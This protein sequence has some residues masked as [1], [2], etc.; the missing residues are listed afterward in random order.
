MLCVGT[1]KNKWNHFGNNKNTDEVGY[2]DILCHS[3][4][5]LRRSKNLKFETSGKLIESLMGD[6]NVLFVLLRTIEY[7]GDKPGCDDDDYE[8]KTALF[9]VFNMDLD[10]NY[11]YNS[12]KVKSLL[13]S[14]IFIHHKE[15]MSVSVNDDCPLPQLING[16]DTGV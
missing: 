15:A 3:Y 12:D 6:D 14:D 16:R 11:S 1:E 5:C 4:I 2:L 10:L 7:V 13:D 8:H 9:L